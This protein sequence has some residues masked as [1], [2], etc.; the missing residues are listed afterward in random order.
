MRAGRNP[1]T[2]EKNTFLGFRTAMPQRFTGPPNFSPF[3]RQSNSPLGPPLRSSNT[4]LAYLVFLVYLSSQ[5]LSSY[6]Y[7]LCIT[8]I[9]AYYIHYIHL[10]TY[11]ENS[12]D[13]NKNRPPMTMRGTS[14]FTQNPYINVCSLT[15]KQRWSLVQRC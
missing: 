4:F 11:G 5:G 9:Y 15:G 2:D 7:D 12:K 8:L 6:P 10:S 14:F 13:K 3:V 1:Q